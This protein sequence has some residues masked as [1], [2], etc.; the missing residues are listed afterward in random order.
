MGQKADI[1]TATDSE[2][3]TAAK[4]E[5]LIA[6]L[7]STPRTH[8]A[9]VD[10]AAGILGLS[11]AMIY[12]LTLAPKLSTLC[13]RDILFVLNTDDRQAFCARSFSDHASSAEISF[14]TTGTHTHT[15]APFSCSEQGRLC[16][17]HRE[18][19]NLCRMMKTRSPLPL[20]EWKAKS[21]RVPTASVR[22]RTAA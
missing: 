5:P 22:R 20:F 19:A 8:R 3:S 12:R 14:R 6:A 10:E 18:L 7:A 17:A 15:S 13:R 16:A 9:Q 11:R 4:R 2:W 1:E 21:I